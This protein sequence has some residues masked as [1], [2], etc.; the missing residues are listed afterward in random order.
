MCVCWW[1]CSDSQ[2]KKLGVTTN[3]IRAVTQHSLSRNYLVIALCSLAVLDV[4][5]TWWA[6]VC[7]VDATAN[8]VFS[9]SASCIKTHA[10]YP[11]ELSLTGR[12]RSF[13][14]P[15]VLDIIF[16]WGWLSLNGIEESRLIGVEVIVCL[17]STTPNGRF[18]RLWHRC[19]TNFM[20]T[21]LF[22][23]FLRVR[24][25][26]FS[27]LMC[28][29]LPPPNFRV[30]WWSVSTNSWNFETIVG[31]R[32][33]DSCPLLGLLSRFSCPSLNDSNRSNTRKSF[34]FVDKRSFKDCLCFYNCSPSLK[35]YIIMFWCT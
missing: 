6:E 12:L 17:I 20:L 30:I 13:W 7:S 31:F 22:L 5:V 19:R 18:H 3:P 33:F 28:R 9:S 2:E 21:W 25:Q 24:W 14:R 11:K 15:G 35:Q 4:E 26:I 10:K 16:V 32:S 34:S 1:V 23:K 8:R 29:F 27:Q